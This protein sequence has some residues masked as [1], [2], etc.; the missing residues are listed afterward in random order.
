[1][2]LL[3]FLGNL[4]EEETLEDAE[5]EAE[6]AVPVSLTPRS[7]FLRRS[8]SHL[9]RWTA[10]TAMAVMKPI[11][12]IATANAKIVVVRLND[13][14]AVSCLCGFRVVVDV[15]DHRLDIKSSICPLLQKKYVSKSER[16]TCALNSVISSVI[17]LGREKS[18]A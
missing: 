9:F 7:R 15:D 13:S 3:N 18:I 6:G 14:V 11:M 16:V 5:L 4:K 17:W 8:F 10:E 12:T 2:R 1:M